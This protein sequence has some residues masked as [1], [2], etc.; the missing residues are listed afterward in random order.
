[1]GGSAVVGAVVGCR[2]APGPAVA[3]AHL[4][5]PGR[6]AIG[7]PWSPC[8]L[9]LHLDSEGYWGNRAAELL[10]VAGPGSIK[11]QRH[12]SRARRWTTSDAVP[13]CRVFAEP[14]PSV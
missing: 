14:M 1:L 13:P 11:A 6:L 8:R 3:G 5:L 12:P 4:A 2:A 7:L 10:V 9:L